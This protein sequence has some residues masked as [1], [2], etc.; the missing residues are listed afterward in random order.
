TWWLG[1]AGGD[2]LVAPAIMVAITHWPYRRAPGRALEAAALALALGGVS[3]LVFPLMIWA[4]LRFWQPGAV[5]ASL[6][7][8]A[9]AIPLTA[10]DH[11]S[12]SGLDLDQ[13]LQ[14]AQTFVG[15]ASM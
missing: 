5:G 3:F 15:V 6:I 8:A 4:A 9:V 12:F 13:R 2:L 11:G 14:L 1:D 7:V 10:D